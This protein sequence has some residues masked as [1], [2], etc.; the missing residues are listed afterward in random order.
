M[1]E[2]ET[3]DQ[4]DDVL[5]TQNL[6]HC[7]QLGCADCYYSNQ[8]KAETAD[9]EVVSDPGILGGSIIKIKIK[10]GPGLSKSQVWWQRE[11]E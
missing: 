5:L 7:Q 11:A 9:D 4:G 2:K 8:R 10:R 6:H 3:E 1:E